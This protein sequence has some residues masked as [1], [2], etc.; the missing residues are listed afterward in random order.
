MKF[1]FVLIV[2]ALSCLTRCN[3]ICERVEKVVSELL[4]V[5]Q[6]DVS[7]LSPFYGMIE[8]FDSFI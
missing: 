2:L 7:N 5:S 4:G 8:V 3:I 1:L 6:D